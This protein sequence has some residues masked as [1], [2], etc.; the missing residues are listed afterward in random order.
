MLAVGPAFFFFPPP[1]HAQYVDA[2]YMGDSNWW[3]SE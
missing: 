1:C 3:Q 2:G